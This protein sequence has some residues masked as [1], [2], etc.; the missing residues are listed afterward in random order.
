MK[1]FYGIS[2]RGLLAGAGAMVAAP[3]LAQ[4][5]APS[6]RPRIPPA[7]PVA[8][9]EELAALPIIK[10]TVVKL[11]NTRPAIME[12]NDLDFDSAG[13]LLVLDQVDQP[14]NKVFVLEVATGRIK[15]SVLTGGLHASGIAPGNGAWW[16]GSTKGDGRLPPQTLKVDPATGKTLKQWETPGWGLYGAVTTPSGAHGIKWVNGQYWM[17]VPASGKLFLMDPESGKV[18]RSIRAP[19]VR[20]HGIAWDNG[21]LWCVGSD[22]QEIYKVDPKDGR[23]LGK[24][25]LT[26]DDPGLHGL[27]IDKTGTLWYCDAGTGWVCKLV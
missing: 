14:T 24:I 19:A 11:Y 13:D 22:D 8:T 26:K 2:R 18:V 10:K 15:R 7:S 16:I 4:T 17:A 1:P 6:A 12:P 3:A 23:L 25:K 27:A 20:S 21:Y 9:A 5:P